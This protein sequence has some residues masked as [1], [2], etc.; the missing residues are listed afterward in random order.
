MKTQFLIMIVLIFLSCSVTAQ[1]N[2]ASVALTAAIYEEEVTGNL[3]KAAELCLDILKEYPD[4]R[5]VAA[6]A[7]YHLGLIH[8]NMG[9]QQAT[10]Y[11]TRLVNTYPDQIEVVALARERLAVLSSPGPRTLTARRLADPPADICVYGAVSPNGQYLSYWDWRTE[12]I[13]VRNLQTGEERPLIDIETQRKENGKIPQSADAPV[14]SP[15]SKRIAYVWQIQDSVGERIEL[16]VVGLDGGK[17]WVISKSSE[18]RDL[19]SLSWSPDGNHI[20]A[21]VS[22][23][24]EPDQIALISTINGSLRLLSDLRH[25]IYPTALRFSSDSH[26]IIY[27]RLVDKL[28]PERDIYLLNINTGQETPLVQHPADDYLLGCSFD[29]QWLVFASDRTGDLGLWIASISGT[30]IQGEPKLVKPIDERILPIGLTRGGSLYY[31][32]VKVTEDVFVVDL[33]PQTGKVTSTPRKMVESYEGGNFTPSFSPDGKSLAYVSRRGNSPYPTNVGNALVIRSLDTGKEKVF[34]REIWGMG[35]RYIGGLKW[36]PDCRFVIFYGMTDNSVQGEYRIDLKVGE[37][38][39]IFLCGPDERLTGGAYGPDG[40]LYSARINF[41]TG[42]SAILMRDLQSGQEQ[43]LIRFPRA[44]GRIRMGLS[45]DGKRLCFFN[46]DTDGERTLSILP[47]S[48]GEVMELWNFEET[49]GRISGIHWSPNGRFILFSALELSDKPIWDLWRIPMEGG[50]PEKAGLQRSFGIYSLTIS[51]DGHG[52]G[53]AS[54]GGY[55]TDSELWVLEDF[56][57]E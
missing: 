35:L 2:Q 52:L 24:N 25:R 17:P 13:T 18:V 38:S 28:N 10:E 50:T 57:P 6:Q 46:V 54:R 56:L 36:S 4:D 8:E 3:D 23:E 43:E 41:G 27:D 21:L 30:E 40:K 48:G 53:F 5:P 7:L 44:E 9:K 39:Q 19:W 33:D 31:G 20:A 14:W 26:H 22:Q 49:Q 55:S 45:P 29:G 12:G 1:E 15:D 37:I 34:Y 47:T 51:P 16:R 42:S 32:V 11:F